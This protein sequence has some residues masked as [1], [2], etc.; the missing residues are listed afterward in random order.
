MSVLEPEEN[1]QNAEG[2]SVNKLAIKVAKLEVQV[3]R[4]RK[5]IVKRIGAWGGIIALAVSVSLGS[6]SLYDNLVLR[7]RHERAASGDELRDIVGRLAEINTRLTEVQFENNPTKLRALSMSVN[8]EKATL[9]TRADSI[10]DSVRS[11]ASFPDL[12][13]LS[14]EHSNFGNAERSLFYAN[15][16]LE[17]AETQQFRGEAL[18]YKGR[19]LFAP[20]PAQ[21]FDAGRRFFNESIAAF[22]KSGVVG[23]AA[24]VLNTYADWILFEAVLQSCDAAQDIYKRLKQ[25]LIKMPAPAAV[26]STTIESISIGL[27][28]NSTCDG[29]IPTSSNR[30]S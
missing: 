16:A 4:E 17:V 10:I 7:P 26:V 21:D 25:E 22:R 1:G 8:A 11:E 14:F 2:A 15:A 28:A 24:L 23:H 3:E 29:I 6:F 20:G 5:S 30:P 12:I 27:E 19:A 18:R 9:I 13:T